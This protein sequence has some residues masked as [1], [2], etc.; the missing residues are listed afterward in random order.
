MTNFGADILFP[1]LVRDADALGIYKALGVPA[2]VVTML[3][4]PRTDII[5]AINLNRPIPIADGFTG[6]VITLD[7][8][9]DSSFPNG[10]R[11]GG[12]SA[13]NRNQVNV[14]S[15]LI[16]L[17]VAGIA[18]VSPRVRFRNSAVICLWKTNSLQ[19]CCCSNY[20]RFQQ[21]V[22]AGC[23]LSFTLTHN[24]ISVCVQNRWPYA[25]R[26]GACLRFA[27]AGRSPSG[28][29]RSFQ[30][31]LCQRSETLLIEAKTLE[32]DLNDR[33]WITQNVSYATVIGVRW[34]VLTN[35]DEYRIYNS[36]AAVDV[37]QK[38]VIGAPAGKGYPPTNG[39]TFWMYTDDADSKLRPVD[40]L[41][42][43]HLAGLP[44]R[45][46]K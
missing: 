19:H 26:Y 18:D 39:W 41:R 30:E 36:H 40:F 24:Q 4:G 42:Q 8:A 27:H 5:R 3:K 45:Q 12:G 38:P 2:S 29:R 37:D 13:Q 44:L 14:N 31:L 16:S 34:C 46:D 10:R 43:T 1:V 15:V 11:L 22:A 9:I 25:S 17:I 20:T 35:G 28:C 7:A 21:F 23:L 6:D 32:K 33:K